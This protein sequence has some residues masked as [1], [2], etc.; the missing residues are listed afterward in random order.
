MADRVEREI[1]EILAKLDTELPADA[2]TKPISILSRRKP[3]RSQATRPPRRPGGAFGGINST[4]VMFAGAG[5]VVG[6][7]VAANLAGPLIWV[8]FAGVVLFLAAFLSSF[9]RHAPASAAQPRGAFWRD[10]YIEYAPA[11]PGLFERIRRAFRR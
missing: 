6:G 3:K 7:L 4:S 8:S 2:E 11:K 5:L 10:R 1:E 9:L